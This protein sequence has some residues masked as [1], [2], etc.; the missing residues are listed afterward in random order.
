MYKLLFIF[1]L[2]VV[3]LTSQDANGAVW[4]YADECYGLIKSGEYETVIKDSKLVIRQDRWNSDAYAC[5]AMAYYLSDRKYLAIK[6]MKEAEDNIP[7]EAVEKVHDNI[8][9]HLPELLAEKEYRDNYT[10]SG[11]ACILRNVTSLSGAGYLVIGN[12]FN[13]VNSTIGRHLRG[14]KCDPNIKE[15]KEIDHVCPDCSIKEEEVRIFIK[16]FRIVEIRKFKNVELSR[17]IRYVKKILEL[18]QKK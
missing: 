1:Y 5:L 8:W 14:Y 7:Q 6:A 12:Y 2:F 3:L 15:C 17:N 10:L 4:K 13:P 11:G 16:D 9:N 18:E